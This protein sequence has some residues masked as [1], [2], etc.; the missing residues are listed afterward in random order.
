M[1]VMDSKI[2]D[3]Y[4]IYLG[5]CNKVMQ[6]FKDESIDLS[7]YSPPFRGLYQYSSDP[8]DV[9]NCVS[10]DEF[11]EH[12]SFT[13]KQLS[14]L[15]KPGRISAVHCMDVPMSNAGCDA[16]HDLPGNIIKIHEGLGFEYG[17]RRVIW[18][19]PLMV[20]NRT[21][22]KSLHHKTFCED[23]T[24][25]SIANSD[26]LLMFRKRGENKIPVKH[27]N[28]MLSYH[29]EYKVPGDLHRMRGME[30]DQKE[31]EYSQWIWR[32]YASSV[33]MDIRIDEVLNFEGAREPEDEKHVHPLQLDVIFRAVDMWSNPGEVVITPYMGVGSEVFGSMMSG[34]KAIGIELKEVYFKQTIKN[35]DIA[36][37]DIKN[38][39][40]S[41]QTE[42]VL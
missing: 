33:W 31:N 7:I 38:K 2:T 23:S 20:R 29:G 35:L 26:F 32:N 30:G 34:R 21:M 9:S 6:S 27:P 11:Y 12:Y 18:K 16:M 1:A 19:E 3:K 24:R 10:T 28:G 41:E 40:I 15:T 13:V 42:L 14:R 17:G 4:A 25:V 8:R 22:M 5:D 37:H 39:F 36:E